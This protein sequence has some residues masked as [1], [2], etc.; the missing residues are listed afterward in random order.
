MHASPADEYLDYLLNRNVGEV[1][2]LTR[3]SEL[4][5]LSREGGFNDNYG[6]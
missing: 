3:R 5:N 1:A 6:N 2:A 4:L